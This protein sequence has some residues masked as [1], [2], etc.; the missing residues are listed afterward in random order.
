MLYTVEVDQ[1]IKIEQS[2]D[3]VLAFAGEISHAV[4]IPSSVKNEGIQ[5]L[6]DRKKSKRQ[7]HLLLFSACLY[8]LL[9]DHLPILSNVVIDEEYTGQ[10]VDIKSFLLNYIRRDGYFFDPKSISFSRIGRKSQA[11]KK[12]EAVRLGRDKGYRKITLEEILRV[13]K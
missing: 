1:S 6:L 13:I 2:G 10:E 3:T 11:H 4:V 7:A 5:A 9:K 8:L 12:V